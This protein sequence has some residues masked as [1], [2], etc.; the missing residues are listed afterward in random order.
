MRTTLLA[1][2]AILAAAT[3]NAGNIEPT[4]LAPAPVF[5][6]PAPIATWTGGYVGAQLGYVDA[7]T[8]GAADVDADGFI[9]GF[10]A[11][12]DY[13]FGGFVLGGL[14]QYDLTSEEFDD[15]DIEAEDVLRAGLRAGVGF[16]PNLAYGLAGYT[17]VGTDDIGDA[18]GYFV[19]A[20]YERLL[21]D[22]ISIG[23]EVIYHDV[24]GFDGDIDADATTAQINL[25]YRF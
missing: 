9:G 19:G 14:L 18:D 10:R 17:E 20:G 4:P 5:V 11:G 1:T 16:G 15:T 13:D 8:S 21:T 6:D 22:S 25:N 24:E 12:Y 7:D 3:A 2:A 23:G